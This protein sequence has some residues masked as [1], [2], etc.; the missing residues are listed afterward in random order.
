MISRILLYNSGGGIGDA[1]QILPLINAL[2]NEFK[3]SNVGKDSLSFEKMNIKETL[4]HISN[5][6]LYIGNDT[7]WAHISVALNIKAI[8][9]FCDSPVAAYGYY[10][11]KMITVEPEGIPKGTTTHDT[12]GKDK[13]SFENVYNESIRIL[14]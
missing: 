9:I 10:S 7:G 12:L 1:L 2:K 6:N 13:V 8:T 14:C 11:K 4:Q 5:C 3:N